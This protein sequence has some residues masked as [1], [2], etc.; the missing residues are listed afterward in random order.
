MGGPGSGRLAGPR[1]LL[2]RLGAAL[3]AIGAVALLLVLFGSATYNFYAY[4]AGA[5]TTATN[6]KYTKDCVTSDAHQD[7]IGTLVVTNPLFDLLNLDACT[8]TWNVGGAS[9]T[10][11]IVG[12]G[13]VRLDGSS[14]DVRVL[15]GKA[16]T[17]TSE[18]HSLLWATGIGIPAIAI[19]LVVW[20]RRRTG[21]STRGWLGGIFE[22]VGDFFSDH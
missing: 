19:A 15:G 12:A 9:Q 3:V 21:R 18:M 8:A 11:P 7:F 16:Y 5:P 1:Y 13:S 2:R 14:L 22:F 17:A 4:R 20:W 6:E 10:G